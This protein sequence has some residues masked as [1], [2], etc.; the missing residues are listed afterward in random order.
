MFCREDLVPVGGRKDLIPVDLYLVTV[1][2]VPIPL[3]LIDFNCSC[4]K[5][6]VPVEFVSIAQNPVQL[7]CALLVPVRISVNSKLVTVKIRNFCS[8]PVKIVSLF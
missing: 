6:V 4:R 7:Y 1:E 5:Y 8:D 3:N 2:L